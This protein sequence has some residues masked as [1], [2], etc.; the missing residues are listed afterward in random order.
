M[1]RG[2]ITG[3][4]FSM[5]DI[6]KGM[7]FRST[8]ISREDK[9]EKRKNMSVIDNELNTASDIEESNFQYFDPSMTNFGGSNVSHHKLTQP[10]SLSRVQNTLNI[11]TAD[12]I[13]TL[14]FNIFSSLQE[15]TMNNFCVFPI[16]ILKTLVA[17]DPNIDNILKISNTREIFH[18]IKKQQNMMISRASASLSLPFEHIK[19]STNYY[20]DNENYCVEFPLL[21]EQFAFGV[22]CSKN[23]YDITLSKKL[24]GELVLNLHRANINVFCPAFKVGNK[25]NMNAVLKEFGYVNSK[26][27]DIKYVQNVYFELKTDV[28][29]KTSVHN[30]VIDLSEN[31][32]YYLRFVPS[33]MILFIGRKI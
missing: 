28:Y 27:S 6:D 10:M 33:N 14:I 1:S 2:E 31:I 25:L 16:G 7:P 11:M 22:I 9:M 18:Q 23:K 4:F 20:E 32:I 15:K 3:E 8:Y 21:E 13:N 17:N 24:F 30:P 12:Y 26:N 29:I 5:T 19:N